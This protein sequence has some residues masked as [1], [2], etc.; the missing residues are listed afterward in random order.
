M[1]IT[2]KSEPPPKLNE[3]NTESRPSSSFD[4]LLMPILDGT[5][6]GMELI[7]TDRGMTVKPIA[8]ANE[9]ESRPAIKTE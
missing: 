4:E 1:I 8:P 2:I 7:P 9:S 5:A 6:D 3:T